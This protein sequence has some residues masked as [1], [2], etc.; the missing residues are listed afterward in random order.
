MRSRKKRAMINN[1][2]VAAADRKATQQAESPVADEAVRETVEAPAAEADA[3]VETEVGEPACQADP[4]AAID[5]VSEVVDE[6]S[7]AT[8]ATAASAST[9]MDW[10]EATTADHIAEA[11]HITARAFDEARN[12]LRSLASPATGQDS[13]FEPLKTGTDFFKEHA[14]PDFA[15]ASEALAEFNTRAMSLWRANA[16][17]ALAHWHSLAGVKSFSEAI[18]LNA[19]FARKQIESLNTHSREMTEIASRMAQEATKSQG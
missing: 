12:R 13:I 6:V 10:M 14:T 5:P 8:E 2:E 3:A 15:R 16:E 4:I 19:E 7:Q 11:S 18:A 9:A 1:S 17:S